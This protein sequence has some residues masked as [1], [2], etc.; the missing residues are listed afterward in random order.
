MN[1]NNLLLNSSIKPLSCNED[2]RI[3]EMLKRGYIAL[4]KEVKYKN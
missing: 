4:N 3:I 1:L 2:M